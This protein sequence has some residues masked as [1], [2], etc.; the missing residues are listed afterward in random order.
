MKPFTNY[1]ALI[2]NIYNEWTTDIIQREFEECAKFD[3]AF[4]KE[5]F[6]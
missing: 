3:L 6:I 2:S 5:K 1:Y 4:K